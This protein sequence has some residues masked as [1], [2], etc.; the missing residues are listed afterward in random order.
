MRVGLSALPETASR[1]GCGP[2]TSSDRAAVRPRTSQAMHNT[3]GP[4]STG[5]GEPPARC[6]LYPG[7][8]PCN[9]RC[10][11]HMF[12]VPRG[13]RRCRR[14]RRPLCGRRWSRLSAARQ[15]AESFLFSHPPSPLR[16]CQPS[17]SVCVC[18]LQPGFACDCLAP[19]PCWSRRGDVLRRPSSRGSSLTVG[20]S[21]DRLRLSALVILSVPQVVQPVA[22]FRRCLW[23]TGDTRDPAHA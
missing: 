16:A 3:T 2:A 7:P 23:V 22:L 12:A 5:R 21:L 13:R 14:R 1:P 9:P 6:C 18:G 20:S 10:H 11:V 17:N 19:L 4:T 8:G 15:L